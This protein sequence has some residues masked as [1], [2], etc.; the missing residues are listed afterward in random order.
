[1]WSYSGPSA[2]SCPVKCVCLCG[3]DSWFALFPVGEICTC[4]FPRA[5]VDRNELNSAAHLLQELGDIVDFLVDDDPRWFEGVLPLDLWQSVIPD[6][7]GAL[8]HIFTHLCPW[9][10]R[11]FGSKDPLKADRSREPACLRL[12]NPT[13]PVRTVTPHNT[14]TFTPVST[15]NSPKFH[16][17]SATAVKTATTQYYTSGFWFQNKCCLCMCGNSSYALTKYAAWSR[18]NF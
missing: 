13:E 7:I 4:R 17:C 14:P 8:F 12:Y 2:Q 16:P 5:S 6:S 10:L 15:N 9:N 3:L 1:M 11:Q 18:N